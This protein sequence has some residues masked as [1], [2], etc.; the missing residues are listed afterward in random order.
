MTDKKAHPPVSDFA[1]RGSR[2]GGCVVS[3]VSLRRRDYLTSII[4]CVAW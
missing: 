1:K 4:L 2:T 3:S